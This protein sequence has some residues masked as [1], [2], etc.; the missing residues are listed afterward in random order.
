[1]SENDAQSTK[2]RVT[3]RLAYLVAAAGIYL[4]DQSSKAWAIR[5]LRFSDR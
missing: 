2:A 1:M 4:M 3:W 5:R